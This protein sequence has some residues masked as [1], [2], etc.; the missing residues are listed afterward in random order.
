MTLCQEAASATNLL[1]YLTSTTAT[2]LPYINL[3]KLI[4]YQE[5]RK[6]FVTYPKLFPPVCAFLICAHPFSLHSLFRP[7]LGDLPIF[8]LIA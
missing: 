1:S 3:V 2:A 6:G 8:M 7:Y 4:I 5:R